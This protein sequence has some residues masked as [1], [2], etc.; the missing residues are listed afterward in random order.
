MIL[1]SPLLV[2]DTLLLEDLGEDGDGRVDGVGNDENVGLGAVLG[3]SLSKG[4]DDRGVRVLIIVSSCRVW[5][6]KP[7]DQRSSRKDRHG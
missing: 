5:D 1:S 4:L 2:K 7:I 3:T 6:R